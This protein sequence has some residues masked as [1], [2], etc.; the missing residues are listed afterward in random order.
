M[1]TDAVL[2]MTMYIAMWMVAAVVVGMD[3]TQIT[4]LSWTLSNHRNVCFMVL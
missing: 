1:D 2:D 3:M 4:I